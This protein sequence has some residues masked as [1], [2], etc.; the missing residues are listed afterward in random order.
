MSDGLF[1]DILQMF[2]RDRTPTAINP[3]NANGNWNLNAIDINWA[4]LPCQYW[5]EW[6]NV[7]NTVAAHQDPLTR[8]IPA[9]DLVES[10]LSLQPAYLDLAAHSTLYTLFNSCPQG[11]QVNQIFWGD[12]YLSMARNLLTMLS[13]DNRQPWTLQQMALMMMIVGTIHSNTDN[14]DQIQDALDRI[15]DEAN[16]QR[17]QIHSYY[18]GICDP[19]SAL[20]VF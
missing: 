5:H 19:H 9:A 3:N 16:H 6:T 8:Y 18:N 14:N 12:R 7:V 4:N 20:I 2:V 11:S 17:I 13:L 1:C 15:D 10:L